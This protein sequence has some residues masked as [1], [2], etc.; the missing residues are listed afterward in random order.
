MKKNLI[1]ITILLTVIF[2]YS[3]N[4]EKLT[5][6]EMQSLLKQYNP[7]FYNIL[8]QEDNNKIDNI[9]S[10]RPAEIPNQTIPQKENNKYD[11][12]EKAKPMEKNRKER[13]GFSPRTGLYRII[14]DK[15]IEAD[16]SD[17]IFLTRNAEW[18]KLWTSPTRSF[19]FMELRGR[20]YTYAYFK[21]QQNNIFEFF[22]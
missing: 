22:F 18:I 8:E 16:F 4:F 10:H 9:S 11:H 5:E 12:I 13:F 19:M 20:I 2:S 3:D 7:E 14:M 17:F 1:L 21:P 6:T 15:Y